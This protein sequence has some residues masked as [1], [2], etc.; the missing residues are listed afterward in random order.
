MAQPLGEAFS[1]NDTSA[2]QE[3]P[4]ASPDTTRT[5]RHLRL[6]PSVVEL[7]DPCWAEPMT[8][9][10]YAAE[11]GPHTNLDDVAFATPHDA[12]EEPIHPVH[13]YTEARSLRCYYA[14]E[15]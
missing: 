6:L 5:T 7:V 3:V 8:Y 10:V 11:R 12:N 13:P 14:S 2:P 15:L 1:Y 4:A 9:V